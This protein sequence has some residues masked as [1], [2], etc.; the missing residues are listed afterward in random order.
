VCN[1]VALGIEITRRS[2]WLAA[3]REMIEFHHEK[4][5][6]SG[7][8]RG[9]RGEAT[10]LAARAVAV[11]GGIARQLDGEVCAAGERGVERIVHRL[12][13][14]ACPAGADKGDRFIVAPTGR[15]AV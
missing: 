10:P 15:H 14:S 5:D 4:F 12:I 13:D 8:L 6:G 1:N 2:S 9:L 11:F 3:A 7:Y